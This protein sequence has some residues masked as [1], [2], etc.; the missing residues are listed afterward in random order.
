MCNMHLRDKNLV[1]QCPGLFRNINNGKGKNSCSGLK[2]L[3]IGN[4]LFTVKIYYSQEFRGEI[5][6]YHRLE[7]TAV[8]Q[9]LK[10][11]SSIS[12]ASSC[13][14]A[15]GLSLERNIPLALH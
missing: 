9:T 15:N 1:L 14:S 2:Q 11:M 8:T 12:T 10:C 3:K 4:D 13:I 7:L 6:C 5:D